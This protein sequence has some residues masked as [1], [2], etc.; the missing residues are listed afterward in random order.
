MRPFDPAAY[1]P[2]LA[3]LLQPQRLPALAV[4]PPDPAWHGP[5]Q[6]LEQE[7]A[8]APF[9]IRDA[10]MAAACRAGLW[11]LFDFFDQAHQQSQDLD[12]PEGSY[13]HALVHRREPDFDN[14]RYWFRRVGRHPIFAAL[15]DEAARLAAAEPH[16]AAGFLSTH[17][18]WD[19][20]AFV[21]LG[22][23]TAALGP[24]A[25]LLCRRVQLCEWQLLF[26]YCHQ[27]GFG[28]D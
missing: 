17:K 22:Q 15:H 2:V 23:S 13:W 16:P 11:L 19:P 25:V 12:T 21:A 20:F 7:A 4:E 9:R 14:A 8:F 6:A 5:L 26:D 27:H 24:D 10:S 3:K 1:G 18:A 28:H